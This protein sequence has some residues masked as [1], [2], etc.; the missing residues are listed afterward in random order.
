MTRWGHR[1]SFV[2]SPNAQ[3]GR[4]RAPPLPP[5]KPWVAVVF[6]VYAVALVATLTAAFVVLLVNAPRLVAAVGAAWQHQL[7]LVVHGRAPSEPLAVAVSLLQLL[8]LT[9]VVAGS[10]YVLAL[11][12]S[13]LGRGLVRLGRRWRRRAPAGAAPSP[14]QR[15]VTTVRRLALTLSPYSK[16]VP[17]L[18]VTLV[19]STVCGYVGYER[20]SP[21]AARP[22]AA[23]RLTAAEVTRGAIQA[24]V[25]AT[26]SVASPAQS[27]LS[28]KSGGRLAALLVKVG[29]AVPAGHPL[30]RIDD[31]EL[32]AG[33][34]QAQAGYA[35]AVAKLEQTRTGTRPEELAAARAAVDQA[36]I[37]LEQTRSAASGPEVAAARR[38]V[39]QARLK[40]D[41]LLNPRPEDAAAARAK[42]D[43]ARAKLQGL[44]Q[45]RPEDL[46]AAQAVLDQARTKLAQLQDQPKT[47]APQD[48]ANAELAVQ[49]AQVAYD[50]ALADAANVDKPGFG[51]TRAAS[52][53]AI[54]QG[55]IQLQTA[56]NNLDKLKQ[57]GP[58]EWEV[59][60]AQEAVSEA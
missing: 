31:A 40:L 33:L 56:Q 60:Q 54:K 9:A 37:R 25:S 46:A 6:G 14:R 55:L 8:L 47:A 4:G 29:D 38:Q 48:V 58:S 41:Q 59:R 42:L 18:V 57:Q 1:L 21:L 39:Q 7:A 22:A 49:R 15:E 51:L 24:T 35:G 20:L 16:V 17:L 28:F 2:S 32:Q 26:G 3:R 43:A 10:G 11:L 53:A 23:S 36:R 50:K 52:D 5:V 45:P 12:A 34:A 19:V 27:K 44:Q 13:P 30:A